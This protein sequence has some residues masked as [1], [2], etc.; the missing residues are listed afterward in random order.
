MNDPGQFERDRESTETVNAGSAARLECDIVMAGGVTS[1]II[2]PGAVEMIARRYSFR[3]IGGTS[4]G[5]IAAAVTAA[6]EFGRRNGRTEQETFRQ[7]GKISK[8][9]AERSGNHSRLFHLFTPEKSTRPLMAL[10]T[11][12]VGDGNVWKKLADVMSLTLTAWQF[13][14]PLI[15]VALAGLYLLSAL[16]LA[17]AVLPFFIALPISGLAM[18]VVWLLTVAYMLVRHWLVAWQSNYYG[19]CTGNTNP[20][21]GGAGATFD[22]LTPWMHRVI[23][24]A[25]GK[26]DG[27]LTFGDLWRA[28][29]PTGGAPSTSAGDSSPRSIELAMIASDISRNRTAQIPF[30]ESPSALYA[31]LAIL[32]D[33]FPGEIVR[34]MEEHQGDYEKEVARLHPNFIRL[35]KPG[36]LPVVFGAR[37]SLSFP[38]LLSAVP[39][40]TPDFATKD[41]E[42]K[43]KLR[44]VWFSDGG[45]TSNFPIHFFDSPIPS[46]PT[47]CLNLID[48]DA[49][50]SRVRALSAEEANQSGADLAHSAKE[51][52]KPIARSQSQERMA[53]H[54]LQVSPGDPK[55]HDDVWGFVTMNKGDEMPVAPFTAF[56]KS[57]GMPLVAF[58]KTLFNTSRCWSDNQMLVAPGVRERVVNIALRE[59]EGGVNLDMP[60]QTIL[61]L[62]FRGRA[63]GMLIAAR[64]DPFEMTDP[65]TGQLDNPRVFT[66]HRWI[67]FRNFMAAFEDL[68]RRFVT[69]RDASDKAADLRRETKLS[70]LIARPTNGVGYDASPAA[71]R[72]YKTF[73]N[74]LEK[75]A[76]QMA[77]RTRAMPDATFDNSA[78]LGRSPRP[79]MHMRLRPLVDTDPRGETADL[80]DPQLAT[81]RSQT[82]QPTTTS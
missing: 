15:I 24:D 6:A 29:L 67:R 53:A 81:H 56:E 69:S 26:L 4:V 23:Q 2:Y 77:D 70:G 11:P 10:A 1:G 42:G 62:D 64:F 73:T 13:C 17:N 75:L 20:A 36:E 60:A 49:E 43:F 72:F 82:Q 14:L 80:P 25:S 57:R 61:E 45:L 44:K 65:E 18:I 21:L 74:K 3:S 48:F 78:P 5:A 55:P 9:L 46:R 54:P 32:K 39:L 35:P 63:A 33:F 8:T 47:F 27:P 66:S 34:W 68:S 40:H 28:P 7:I 12:I 71:R 30:L 16:L 50:A 52:A 38:F 31:D 59:N 22:G 41:N 76:C 79:K 58:F 51:E 19:V 37:L